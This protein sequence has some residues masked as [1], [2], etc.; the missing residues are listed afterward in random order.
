[1]LN[2]NFEANQLL[3][4]NFQI[5]TDG[6]LRWLVAAIQF[7]SVQRGCVTVLQFGFE[8]PINMSLVSME[9]NVSQ[10]ITCQRQ[11]HCFSLTFYQTMQTKRMNFEKLWLIT[12]FVNNKHDNC[13]PFKFVHPCLFCICLLLMFLMVVFMRFHQ[14]WWQ[15]P[16]F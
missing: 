4:V 1:M 16:L 11:D 5:E 8:L 14:I 10:E 3:K 2:W 12:V 6:R 9:I 7:F 15:F 13:N